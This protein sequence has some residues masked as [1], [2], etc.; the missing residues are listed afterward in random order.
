[1]NPPQSIHFNSVH[2]RLFLPRDGQGPH[3]LAPERSRHAT[4]QLC[5]RS[6]KDT[7]FVSYFYYLASSD[8]YLVEQVYRILLELVRNPQ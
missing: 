6:Q 8:F 7:T 4:K 2:P 5:G 1:M 3:D